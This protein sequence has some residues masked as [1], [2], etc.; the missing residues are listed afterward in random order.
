MLHTKQGI[1]GIAVIVLNWLGIQTDQDNVCKTCSKKYE[2]INV[3][4]KGAC[5]KKGLKVQTEFDK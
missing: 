3:S 2:K 4:L 5:L 1:G